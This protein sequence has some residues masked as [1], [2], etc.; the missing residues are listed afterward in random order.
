MLSIVKPI[1]STEF[2]IPIHLIEIIESS[3][4]NE[5]KIPEMAS[6]IKENEH[7]ILKIKYGGDFSNRLGFYVRIKNYQYPQFE[8]LKKISLGFMMDFEENQYICECPICFDE[9]Y[10]AN[11]FKCMHH[12]CNHCY[13]KLNEAKKCPFCRSS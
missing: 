6:P 7:T 8:R 13:D 10:V 12:L 9:K 11:R 1:L 5:N 2:R 4:Y 3:Q